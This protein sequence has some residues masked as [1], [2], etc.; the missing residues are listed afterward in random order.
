MTLPVEA[1]L[2][3]LLA[4]LERHPRVILEAP[5]GAGKTTRVPLALLDA[6]WL[7][8]RRILMLEPRRIAA[9]AAAGFMA[10]SL[11]E[12]PGQTVGYRIRFEARVSAATRIEVVTE[13]ILTR[14]IQSDPELAG[15]GAILFDEF[16]ERHLQGDLGAALALEVQAGLRPDLRLAL[17]SAT[18]DGER[19]ARWFDAP[20]I[21][22]AG[23][24]FPVTIHHPPTRAG[25]AWPEPGWPQH[26]RR[27]VAAALAESDGD[28]LA[29]LP[30]RR[31]I[32][33]AAEALAGLAETIPRLEVVPLHGEL[34]L[35]AQRAALAPAAPGSRRVVLATNLAESSLTLPGVRAV[36]DL[37]LAREPRFDP[38]TGFT[39]LATV[40][41]S[42]ASAEQRAGRAGRLAPGSCYRLW[43]ESR[44]LEAERR[45]EIAQVELSR[46][47]LE[48]AAWGSAELPWLDAPPPGALAQAR[49]LL[50]RLGA[51]AA[52]GQVNDFGRQLLEL[53]IEPRLGAALARAPAV[54]RELACDAVALAEA[55]NPLRGEAGRSDDFRLRVAAL[56]AWRAERA[57]GARRFGADGAALAHLAR[58]ASALRDRLGRCP[59]PQASSAAGHAATAIG[60]LLLHAYPDRIARQDP[61]RPLRYMLANG[62]GAHL[63][64]ASALIGE[65]WLVA[66]E[67]RAE[68]G[69]S[70]ILAAAPFDPQRL[71]D[72]FA[73]R[74]TTARRV[75]WR[76]DG[77]RPEAFEEE[78]FDGIVLAR[79]SVPLAPADRAAALLAALRE[80]G[81][82]LLPWNEA[83][84]QLRARVATLAGA[85]LAEAFPD[86][87]EAALLATAG[88]WLG[89]LLANARSLAVLEPAALHAAL[90]GQLDHRQR[91]LLDSEAPTT[92]TVPSGQARRIDYADP[93]APV[94]AVKLQE[95]FG[96]AATPRIAA[97]RLPLTLHLLSPAGRPM[98]VTQDLAGFWQRTYPQVRKE[99]K[100]RYPKHPWPEDPW[101]ATPTHRA[102][103]RGGG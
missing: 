3:E 71:Q 57:G 96:L 101:S 42:R 45:P 2:P 75:E 51:L 40:P 67:L 59:A 9:R 18:L 47:A 23:R 77:E 65:P 91:R 29:F 83:S 17:M 4:S 82:D 22:S 54:L 60:D 19:L 27:A 5:P 10:E 52:D 50:Q 53:G 79:R 37:G 28:V 24:S 92:I 95:L 94:L 44:R 38:N 66:T 74:F 90:L 103:P 8:G 58:T 14:L 63:G 46:L 30:G 61:E 102:K 99:L 98:Q 64:E 39:R 33:R 88:D 85:G 13:G 48:L 34:E 70:L 7:A 55:R 31:E 100:G 72:D 81:L 84:R 15:V 12:A 89:P 49:E 6:P 41:V 86:F 26:L 35:A 73:E 21:T 76:R 32:G 25:E 78:R 93:A 87:A 1:V 68:A 20:R 16:H 80:G 56:A 97:G 43:P 62:R 36:V 11:G 69:D